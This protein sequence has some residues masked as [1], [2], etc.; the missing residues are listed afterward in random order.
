MIGFGN[1]AQCVCKAALGLEMNVLVHTRTENE[2]LEE[3]LGFTYASLD[4]VLAKSDVV[5]IHTPSTPDT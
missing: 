4:E 3:E 2:G 5:S 1:I